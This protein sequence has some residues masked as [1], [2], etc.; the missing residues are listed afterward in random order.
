MRASEGQPGTLELDRFLPYRLSVLSNMVSQSIASLYGERFQLSVTEWRVLAVLGRYPGLSAGEVA[1]RT[2]MDKV[3]VSRAVAQLLAAGRIQRGTDRQDRRRSVLKL[4]ARGTRVYREIVPL[5]QACE[6]RLL[7]VLSPH[8]RDQLDHI[9]G[10]LA[11]AGISALRE[12][13][14]TPG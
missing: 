12:A 1:E 11:G 5:A 7:S 14:N 8:E 10:K 4:S 3:A 9:V 2:Q 13:I 6:A